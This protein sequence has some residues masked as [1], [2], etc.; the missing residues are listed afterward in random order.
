MAIDPNPAPLGECDDPAAVLA[1]VRAEQAAAETAQ[2]RVLEGAVAWAAM[3][4]TDSLDDAACLPGA[5]GEIAIAGPGAPLV[6]EFAPLEL[7]AALGMSSDA[8]RAMLGE[9]VELAHRLPKTW[10]AVR[11]G[12]VPAWR[13]RKVAA[14]TLSLPA[15]GAAYVDQHVYAVA[16]KIGYA[17]LDRLIEEARVRFDP[18]GAE[19]KRRAAADRRH[20]DL[21]TGRVTLEGT[22]V[23]DG[24]LDLADA[25]DL[26]SA[27]ARGARILGE[28]G[29][30][31]SL[32]VRRSLAVGEL[33]RR[34]LALDL[35]TTP[36]EIEGL[37]KRCRPRRVVIHVHLSAA[38]LGSP[39]DDT[40]TDDVHL[41]RVE[42]TRSFV[43]ANQV[44]DWCANPD[45]QVI[46]KPVI[47]LADVDHTD[48]YEIP[49]RMAERVHLNNPTCVFPWCGR[50]AR[51]A[52][53][54]HVVPHRH[55]REGPPPGE[56][57]FG[58]TADPNL[59]PLCRPHHRAKT[60]SAWSYTKLDETTF[61]WRTPNGIHLRRDH[62]GTTIVPD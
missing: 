26:E 42:N 48:A 60:H 38:A 61:L 1:F 20:F 46:V 12:E 44:K 13:G 7:G 9:A 11:A 55:E 25:L 16:G 24:E 37:T 22:V 49:D 14:N 32:D 45:A 56:G 54:D 51:R 59:A 21:D 27:V 6:T 31:V 19:E 52:D 10:A 2:V 34:Q 5:E 43:S 39:T 4:S 23:V 58:E 57:G 53:T 30:E 3:H 41:A 18:A 35:D 15:D 28:L 40:D 36:A 62:T 17:A 29:C 8:A 50:S 33:A 47:D